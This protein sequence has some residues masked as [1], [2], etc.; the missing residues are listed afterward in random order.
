[1]LDSLSSGLISFAVSVINLFPGSPFLFIQNLA[2][3]PAM[4]S[5]LGML[6]WFIPVYS[7]VA[8]METWLIGVGIYY[9]YQIVLRWLKAVG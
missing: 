1:M 7:F 6:N 2:S 9:V 4:A 3:D 5:I 8:I